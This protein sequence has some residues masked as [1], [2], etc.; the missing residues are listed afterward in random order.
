MIDHEVPLVP[1]LVLMLVLVRL[2]VPPL[3]AGRPV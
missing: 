2:P 1:V 3:R